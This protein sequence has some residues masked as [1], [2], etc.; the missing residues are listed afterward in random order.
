MRIYAASDEET[1]RFRR[2]IKNWTAEGFLTDAQRVL[3]ENDIPSSLK[4]TNEFLRGVLFLFTCGVMAAAVALY[5]SFWKINNSASESV[6]FFIF[7]VMNY[8]LAEGVIRRSRFYRH[9]IEEA[10]V[11][12]AA[13]F[14]G[15]SLSSALS[16]NLSF[17]YQGRMG[18][19]MMAETAAAFFLYVRFGYH[20]LFFMA[21]IFLAW[22]FCSFGN[23]SSVWNIDDFRRSMVIGSY[24]LGL[25]GVVVARRGHAYDFWDEEYGVIEAL[26]WLALYLSCNLHLIHGADVARLFYWASFLMIWLL[27]IVALRRALMQKDKP[28]LGV[29]IGMMLLTLITN[30]PYLHWT[31]HTWDPMILGVFLVGIVLFIRRWLA[32]GVEGVRRGFT[33]RRLSASDQRLLQTLSSASGLWSSSLHSSGPTHNTAKPEWGGGQSGGGGASSSF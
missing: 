1:L 27:P 11:V 19:V 30:K 9:G 22:T 3:L 17:T 12:M 6:V 7:A 31:R 4:R 32:Q 15:F 16:V 5:F 24:L 10:C 21:L 8:G 14:L 20:Y 2:L 33:A 18:L 23:S 25:V 13:V 26:L 28:L 29:G